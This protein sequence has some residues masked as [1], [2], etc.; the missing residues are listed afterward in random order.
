MSKLKFIAWDKFNKKML[1]TSDL[2]LKFN[3]F[4]TINVI[5]LTNNSK[6]QK[7]SNYDI[8]QYTEIDDKHHEEIYDG[9]I[10]KADGKV[11]RVFKRLGC[12]FVENY[13]ELGYCKDIKIIG[14][15]YENPELLEKK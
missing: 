3:Q 12:W 13:K 1:K 4:G 9:Y 10:V 2:R 14:N 7:T 15:I 11:G 8:L 6:M 5:N